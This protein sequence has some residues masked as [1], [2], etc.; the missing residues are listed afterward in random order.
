MS[1]N[2]FYLSSNK[3][4][5]VLL[6]NIMRHLKVM[7]SLTKLDMIKEMIDHHVPLEIGK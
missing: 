2:S 6:Y 3:A 5:L 7:A 1:L 4:F